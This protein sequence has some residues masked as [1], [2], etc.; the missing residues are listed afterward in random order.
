MVKAETD[1]AIRAIV[2][3]GLAFHITIEGAEP[4]HRVRT[5]H[6]GALPDLPDPSINLCASAGKI[7]MPLEH[8]V[9][10]LAAKLAARARQRRSHTGQS[11]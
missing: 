6:C 7:S 1:S 4:H 8:L 9:K 5:D 2:S 3:A 11:R 10:L